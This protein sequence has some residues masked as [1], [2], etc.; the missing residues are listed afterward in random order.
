[1]K[2][3]DATDRR[4]LAEAAYADDRY[5]AARQAL[6]RWQQPKYDLP[7]IALGM[8]AG[9]DGPVVDVGCGNGNYLRALR[10]ARPDLVVTGIDVSLGMVRDLPPPV[11]VADAQELPLPDR[12][13]G[14]LRWHG[15]VCRRPDP[16]PGHQAS[17]RDAA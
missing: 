10:S 15:R 5:L 17:P 14:G 11:V 9:A 12:S 4:D 6:Y 16:S 3:F 1:M 13:A 8:L 2:E 7:N